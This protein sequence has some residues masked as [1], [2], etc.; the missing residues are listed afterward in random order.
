MSI[1]SSMTKGKNER[2]ALAA[3]ESAK[4][5]TSVRIRYLTVENTSPENR[6]LSAGG[7]K[8][9]GLSGGGAA[10]VVRS[11]TGGWVKSYQSKGFALRIRGWGSDGVISLPLLK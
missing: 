1:I 6:G 2:M 4:V 11:G 5:C 7:A 8:A 10:L 3:T 9:G